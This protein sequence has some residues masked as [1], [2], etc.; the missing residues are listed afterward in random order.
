[1]YIDNKK[2]DIL[3]LGKGPIQ[4]LNDTTVTEEAKYYI[5][6]HKTKKKI[7]FQSALYENLH[8]G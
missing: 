6:F 3:V 2:K 1:M 7:S 8:I 4:E 5:K